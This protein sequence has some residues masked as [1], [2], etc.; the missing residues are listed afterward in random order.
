MTAS[1]R[2]AVA[3]GVATCAAVVSMLA[4]CG[5][6]SSPHPAADPA[7]PHVSVSG[8]ATNGRPPASSAPPQPI[9]ATG[10][11][12]AQDNGTGSRVVR[13]RATRPGVR[14][15]VRLTCSGPGPARV[16]DGSGGLIL[17]TGGCERGVIFSSAWTATKHDG[18]SIQVVV[19]P[20]TSWAVELWSGTVPVHTL[21]T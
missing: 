12:L 20:M 3:G 1:H 16:T 7:S 11:L 13:A 19:G 17:G 6:S 10:S 2:R 5:D 4:G 14:L 15:T 18:R 21:T 8:S 9:G